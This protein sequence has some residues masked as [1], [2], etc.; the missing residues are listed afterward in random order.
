MGLKLKKKPAILP[1]SV[2]FEEKWKLI[3]N[4]AEKKLIEELFVE[5]ENFIASI[6]AQIQLEMKDRNTNDFLR[7]LREIDRNRAQSKHQLEQR[8]IKKW[9]KFRERE[10]GSLIAKINKR[11]SKRNSVKIKVAEDRSSKRNNSTEDKESLVQNINVD[12]R[13]IT[14]SRLQRRKK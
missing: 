14:D 2:N 12:T 5:P 6:E 13:Y 1:A 11:L 8:R 4:E 7:E 3:L 10:R 9:E